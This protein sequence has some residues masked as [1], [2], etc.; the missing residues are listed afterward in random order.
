[1]A[2][3]FATMISFAETRM[4]IT[5]KVTSIFLAGSSLGGMTLPWLVGQLF[6]TVG[7]NAMVW[8]VLITTLM[9]TGMFALINYAAGH[10]RPKA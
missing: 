5:G 4:R 3:M 7:P 10:M 6:E 2:S 9:A 8:A 1:M